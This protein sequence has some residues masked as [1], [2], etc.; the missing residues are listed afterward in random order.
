MPAYFRVDIP[1]IFEFKGG[2]LFIYQRTS[3]HIPVRLENYSVPYQTRIIKSQETKQWYWGRDR[4]IVSGPE[5]RKHTYMG[6]VTLQ[7]SRKGTTPK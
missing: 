7:I 2:L 4:K 3:I 1:E 5:Q 6:E